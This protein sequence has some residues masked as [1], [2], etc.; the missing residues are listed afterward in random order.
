MLLP[1]RDLFES[2]HLPYVFIQGG[3]GAIGAT[4]STSERIPLGLI[5]LSMHY[6]ITDHVRLS[7]IGRVEHE[8]HYGLRSL[9]VV[10]NV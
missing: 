5:G 1:Q 10:F 9:L 2:R 7:L 8:L 4:G 3:H 6:G